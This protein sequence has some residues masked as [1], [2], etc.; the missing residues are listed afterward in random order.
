MNGIAPPLKEKRVPGQEDA[1]NQKATTLERGP[2]R[3]FWQP[4]P[5]GGWRSPIFLMATAPPPPPPPQY[6]IL[7]GP[8][9]SRSKQRRL[10]IDRFVPGTGYGKGCCARC[11]EHIWLGPNQLAKIAA[12]PGIEIVCMTCILPELAAGLQDGRVTDLGGRGP[13]YHMTSG[14]Y[15]GAR[16]EDNK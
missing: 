5:G 14:R 6:L 1:P 7:F 16:E 8:P 10:G 15:W 13:S 9:V 12:T 3:D 11:A 2:I 4:L